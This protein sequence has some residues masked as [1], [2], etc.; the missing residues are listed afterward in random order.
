MVSLKS[1]LTLGLIG[2][3]IAAFYGLGG[4]SGIG[5]R[6]GQGFRSLGEGFT[7]GISSL[8]PTTVTG[9]TPSNTALQNLQSN[10]LGLQKGAS[11]IVEGISN[12]GGSLNPQ[13]S[14][15]GAGDTPSIP[16]N[17][18]NASVGLEAAARAGVVSQAF[19]TTYSRPVTASSGQLD[20]SKAFDFIARNPTS[21][22]RAQS[23]FGG[24]GSAI[25]QNTALAKA[26]EQSSRQYPEYFA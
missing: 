14:A 19:A 6:V 17:T 4:S 5:I 22:S 2:G 3:A 21:T 12:L 9:G 13:T 15:A 18:P 16:T 23:S 26:I 1:L 10:A 8:I 20:V 24:Y 7:A 25:N 11:A